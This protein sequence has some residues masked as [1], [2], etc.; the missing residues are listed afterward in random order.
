MGNRAQILTMAS[1][2]KQVWELAKLA[3]AVTRIRQL[4]LGVAQLVEEG[5][6]QGVDGRL[7]LR[8][9]ILKQLRNQING[10]GVGF[11]KN[12]AERMG[13]D[14]GELVLHVVGVHGANLFASGRSQDLDNLDELINTRLA[15]EEG[16]SEHELSH[17]TSRRPNVFSKVIC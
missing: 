9:C 16:L 2:V 12:L 17:Y 4:C 8:W 1:K 11:A 3:R 5:V 15:R 10:I 14:L 13:L 7:S 6:Y